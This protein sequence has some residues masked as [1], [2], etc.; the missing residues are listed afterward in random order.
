MH[1]FVL[2]RHRC[3]FT[4]L[5]LDVK[6]IVQVTYAVH[7]ASGSDVI[8]AISVIVMVTAAGAL[9]AFDMNQLRES[10]RLFVR[11]IRLIASEAC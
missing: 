6:P 9:V 11:N 10:A 1:L 2:C 8:A 7:E 3:C 4:M 5:M